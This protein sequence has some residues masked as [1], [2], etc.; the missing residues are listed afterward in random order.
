MAAYLDDRNAELLDGV[1]TAA[2]LVARADGRVDPVERGVL[3]DVMD[4]NGLLAV[5]TRG[6]IVEA[7]EARVRELAA[8]DGDDAAIDAL[9]RFAGRAAARLL[10]DAGK[11][12]AAADGHLHPGELRTLQL[13]SRAVHAARPHPLPA[14]RALGGRR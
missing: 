10:L 14:M 7:F 9:G 3:L 6:E 11:H 8:L 2:A 12:V 4:R 5:F 1:A 13:I